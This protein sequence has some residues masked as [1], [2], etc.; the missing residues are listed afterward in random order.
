M[1][2]NPIRILLIAVAFLIGGV[3]AQAQQS[4]QTIYSWS[5]TKVGGSIEMMGAVPSESLP[6]FLRVRA[7]G[8]TEDSTSVTDGA[9]E[10]FALNAIAAI[11]ALARLDEGRVA[12]TGAKWTVAGSVE[13]EAERDALLNELGASAAIDEWIIFVDVI[14]PEPEA[15]QSAAEAEPSTE[16]VAEEATD[17]A[18]SQGAEQAVNAINDVATAGVIAF[19]PPVIW[20]T[21][22][23]GDHCRAA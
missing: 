12:Y 14:E 20:G 5:A 1:A 8:E 21:R 17:P 13:T 22:T 4:I 2:A 9:P 16:P 18:T 19:E 23:G 6:K 15:E 7:G 10:G 11:T 3:S